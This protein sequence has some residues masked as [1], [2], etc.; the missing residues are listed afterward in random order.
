MKPISKAVKD[1]LV[2]DKENGMKYKDLSEKYEISISG[3]RKIYELFKIRKSNESLRKM[4]GRKLKTTKRDDNRIITLAKKKPFSSSRE[5]KE[6]LN[7]SISSRTVRR[8][9]NQKGINN[10]YSKKKPLLRAAN[11]R[12][13]LLFAKKYVNMPESFWNRVIWSDESK[14]E[15]KNPKR[16]KRVW[17]EPSQRLKSKHITHTVKHGGGS[18]MVWGCF[19]SL[20]LGRLVRIDTKMT[21]E[22]YV[23]I[24]QENLNGSAL[25]MGLGD[26]IFQQ[27]ND[28]KHTSKVAKNFF[29]QNNIEVLEWPPQSPDLNPIEHLWTILDDKIPMESRTNT[30]T[31]WEKMQAE[32]REIPLQTLKNLTSSMS[33][34]LR[35]VIANKGG[36]TKY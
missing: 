31:F 6:E 5:I 28:P 2:K 3:A 13:R 34:R 32:W 18:L 15:L 7:L 25:D 24:L 1:L 36:A 30:Q 35:E 14:Y 16:A 11:I 21:G 26:F 33:K 29:Q 10:F 23:G 22:H 17:C 20:G 12:K 8:R 9:L 19:S 27:D 4:S